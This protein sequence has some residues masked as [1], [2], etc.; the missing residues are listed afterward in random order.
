MQEMLQV[1]DQRFL[2]GVL[3]IG[4][5]GVT[6]IDHVVRALAEADQGVDQAGLSQDLLG[7][8]LHAGVLQLGVRAGAAELLER[9]EQGRGRLEQLPVVPQAGSTPSAGG[10][11]R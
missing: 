4:A 9:P 5:E 11:T 3:Q 7:V 10:S 1:L 6:S 8:H 2:L